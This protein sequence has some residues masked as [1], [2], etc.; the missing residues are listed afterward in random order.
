MPHESIELDSFVSNLVCVYGSLKK[1]FSSL[2]KQKAFCSAALPVSYRMT[3]IFRHEFMF[4]KYH[5][6]RS[7][8]V[9]LHPQQNCSLSISTFLL[10]FLQRYRIALAD[11]NTPP[12]HIFSRLYCSFLLLSHYYFF[13]LE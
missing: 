9:F 12:T 11:N 3:V 2:H 7:E 5:T 4:L 1:T 13:S 10:I 6:T 8:P